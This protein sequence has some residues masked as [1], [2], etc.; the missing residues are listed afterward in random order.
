LARPPMYPPRPNDAIACN[1]TNNPDSS[2]SA[3]EASRHVGEAD[4]IDKPTA[5]PNASNTELRAA[6]QSAP[7]MTDRH[8]ISPSA[9]PVVCLSVSMSVQPEERQD[10]HDDDD[11]AD[12]INQTIHGKSPRF[13]IQS[14]VSQQGSFDACRQIRFCRWTNAMPSGPGARRLHVTS[15]QADRQIDD[16]VPSPGKSPPRFV[17]TRMSRELTGLLLGAFGVLQQVVGLAH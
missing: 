14:R 2:A 15:S 9:T 5:V 7:A 6:A 1:R 11:Q 8:L 17:F 13:R 12:Q 4:D 16:L 10:R 3:A